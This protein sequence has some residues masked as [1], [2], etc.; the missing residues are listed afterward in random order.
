MILLHSVALALNLC[1]SLLFT[2]QNLAWVSQGKTLLSQPVVGDIC[3]NNSMNIF[4]D[5]KHDTIWK[6]KQNHMHDKQ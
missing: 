6:Q 5:K 2:L 1:S 3:E 4:L